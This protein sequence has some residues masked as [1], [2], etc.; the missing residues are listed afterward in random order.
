MRNDSMLD[1]NLNFLDLG[2]FI[3][4][5]EYIN[6]KYL[7][8]F[9]LLTLFALK[10]VAQRSEDNFGWENRFALM[11]GGG[12]SIVINDLYEDPVIDRVTGNVIIEKTDKLR[13]NLSIGLMYTPYVVD[14][15]R[16][17]STLD[18][19]GKAVKL[20]VIEHYPK[21]IT[22]G[23]FLN[24]VTLASLSNTSLASTVDLGFGIGYR[25]KNVAL[26]LTSEFFRV[27]QPRE[28]FVE[29]HEQ[30]NMPFT[31]NDELQTAID[32]SDRS[33]FKNKVV[34]SVGLKLAY[35]FS[36]VKAISKEIAIE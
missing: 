23:L 31:I 26:L 16:T 8:L 35:S 27:N 12:T 11:V 14:V 20:K 10:L 36:L 13:P 34:T 30:N 17:I 9:I 28:Y 7:H 19:K 6:M 25:A 2:Y 29:R 4:L 15:E 5:M 21:G 32:T 3:V 18:D 22:F 33:I 24:P 1:I